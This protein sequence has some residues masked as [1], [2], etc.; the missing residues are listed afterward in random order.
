GGSRAPTLETL[1]TPPSPS[2]PGDLVRERRPV[3]APPGAARSAVAAKEARAQQ[4]RWLLLRAQ[5]AVQGGA[6]CARLPCR[7]PGR[8]LGRDPA[9]RGDSA[10]HAYAPAGGD[11]RAGLHRRCRLRRT[12]SDVGD[13]ADGG[14]RADDAARAVPAALGRRRIPHAGTD[15]RRVEVTLSI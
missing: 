15:R 5:P 4:A 13:P 7:W 14:R 8:R 2:R 11:R 12:D 6:R 3:P 9:G 10:A 1:N